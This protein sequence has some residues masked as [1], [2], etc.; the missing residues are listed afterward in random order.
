MGQ[1][2]EGRN[3]QQGTRGRRPAAEPPPTVSI[4]FVEDRS[5]LEYPT[6]FK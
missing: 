4:G 2:E 1:F 5:L 6:K 3:M